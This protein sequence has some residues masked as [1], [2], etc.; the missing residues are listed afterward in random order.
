[1]RA[2]GVVGWGGILLGP[3]PVPGAGEPRKEPTLRETEE[4]AVKASRA[5]VARALGATGLKLPEGMLDQIGKVL[6]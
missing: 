5:R 2:F 4:A 6:R 1:M 3:A